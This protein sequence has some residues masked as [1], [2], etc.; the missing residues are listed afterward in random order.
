MN[1]SQV[2]RARLPTHASDRLG[3]SSLNQDCMFL[4]WD[5]PVG[6]GMVLPFMEHEPIPLLGVQFSSWRRYSAVIS[7][8][9]VKESF[10][11][12]LGTFFLWSHSHGQGRQFW[13]KV[14]R[15]LV[16]VLVQQWAVI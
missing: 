9:N 7:Q 8:E 1:S 14:D 10:G 6:I 12:F 15:S 5:F 16:F 11:A 13:V 4:R 3:L 2:L